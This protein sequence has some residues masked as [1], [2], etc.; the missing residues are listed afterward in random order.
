VVHELLTKL[1]ATFEVHKVQVVAN[2]P[3]RDGYDG[4]LIAVG[5]TAPF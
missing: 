2:D 5:T 4:M 1:N 3:L